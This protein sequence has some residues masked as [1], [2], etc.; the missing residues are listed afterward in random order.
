MGLLLTLC[1]PKRVWV[2]VLSVGIGSVAVTGALGDS[3]NTGLGSKVS[4]FRAHHNMDVSPTVLPSVVEYRI[5]AVIHGRVAAWSFVANEHPHMS[6]DEKLALLASD[7]LYLGYKPLKYTG[8]CFLGK[9]TVL[10]RLLGRAFIQGDATPGLDAGT[11]EATNHPS[12]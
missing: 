11:V 10:R 4:V 6:D 3:V 2:V 12:C 1:A 5:D 7:N 9:T 8:H